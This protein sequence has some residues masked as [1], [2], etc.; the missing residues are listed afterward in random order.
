MDRCARCDGTGSRFVVAVE[1][2]VL[3]FP[4]TRRGYEQ[5][6]AK[7]GKTPEPNPR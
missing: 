5:A 6:M 2:R 7:L 3:Y 4:N 1:G